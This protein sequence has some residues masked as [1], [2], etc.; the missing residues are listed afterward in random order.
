MIQ[1]RKEKSS[2]WVK[3]GY[4]RRRFEENAYTNDLLLDLNGDFASV[5][6]VEGLGN[7]AGESD[8]DVLAKGDAIRGDSQAI[9][10]DGRATC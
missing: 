4:R 5:G 8:G 1:Q 2:T 7:A 9:E 6:G 3:N 10:A